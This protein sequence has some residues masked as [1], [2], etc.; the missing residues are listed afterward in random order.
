M[1]LKQS[2]RYKHTIKFTVF[3]LNVKISLGLTLAIKIRVP[4]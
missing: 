3:T 1:S 2:G 4:F